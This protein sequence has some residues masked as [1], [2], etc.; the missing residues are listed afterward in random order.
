MINAVLFLD[1]C[2]TAVT[3]Y[4]YNIYM[5]VYVWYNT[6]LYWLSSNICTAY[7]NVK[8]YSALDDNDN[9]ITAELLTYYK[10]YNHC[11]DP[12]SMIRFIRKW[13]NTTPDV[14]D[15]VYEIDGE[16]YNSRFSLNDFILVEQ[17]TG[18]EI[19]DDSLDLFTI[20]GVGFNQ[21]SSI[22]NC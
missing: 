17:Y 9:D 6:V 16:F 3:S 20:P 12:T 22:N 4:V 5:F 13:T 19:T 1:D 2:R 21:P 11:A 8:I 14:V 7:N 18:Q 15:L 10:I